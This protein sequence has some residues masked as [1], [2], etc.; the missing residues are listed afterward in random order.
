MS[1]RIPLIQS[2][3]CLN[4]TSPVLEPLQQQS[5]ASS[6]QSDGSGELEPGFKYRSLPH[7]VQ[8][9]RSDNDYQLTGGGDQ[10]AAGLDRGARPDEDFLSVTD[11]RPD[12]ADHDDRDEVSCMNDFMI[13]VLLLLL[14]LYVP[15]MHTCRITIGKSIKHSVARQTAAST[16]IILTTPTTNHSHQTFN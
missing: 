14:L 6:I 10:P 7:S 5:E 16:I 12:S 15:F 13:I 4:T 2:E 3:P 11:S 1:V 8:E 9:N